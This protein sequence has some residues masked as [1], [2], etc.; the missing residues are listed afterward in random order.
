MG[1]VKAQALINVARTCLKSRCAAGRYLLSSRAS[2]Q[3]R[4]RVDGTVRQAPTR[5]R[6]V[7]RWAAPA[8]T[9]TL[10]LGGLALLHL[11]TPG[12]HSFYPPCPLLRLTG[13]YCPFCGGLRATADLTHGDVAGAFARNPIVPPL[14][15][16]AVVAWGRW[17]WSRVTGR[18]WRP[19]LGAR[20]TY[21]VLGFLVV[22]MIARN[23]P[24]W[25]WLSPA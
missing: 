24:G 20:T 22:F 3:Y 5:P 14:L 10:G 16:V 17:A 21:W 13:L 18:H 12:A 23:V 8:L 6:D 25:T 15:L 9:A 11:R 2:A 1:W 7:R 4:W 19:A